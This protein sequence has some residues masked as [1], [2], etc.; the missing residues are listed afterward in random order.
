MRE[1]RLQLLDPLVEPPHVLEQQADRLLDLARLLAH[2][3][4]L[5]DGAHGVQR[6]H[7]GGGR[8][9]PDAGAVGLVDQAG[10]VGVQLGVD[11]LRG[12]EHQRRFGGLAGH[13]VFVAD[14]ADVL[15]DRLLEA[16]L[17][18]DQRR[19]V[20][21]RHGA[22]RAIALERELGV[23]GDRARRVGQLQ[24]AIDAH[25]GGQRRLEFVGR[26]R[27][28]VL[29][30][31]VELDLAE[32]AARLLVGQD[33]LQAHDLGRELADL[34]LRL[35]DADQPLAQ[36]GDDLAR[37]LLGAVEPLVDHLG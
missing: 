35:V 5:Q 34:L 24:Q 3:H 18:D 9:D 16:A 25:A 23:D 14:V 31:V 21:C 36:V 22:Q 20:A 11:R 29:H 12:Q 32:G 37:R 1:V 10:E 30:Q 15:A 6:R 4:V 19:R 7:H 8:H 13:D 2:A 28:R 33:L 17:G 27:Q 26:G